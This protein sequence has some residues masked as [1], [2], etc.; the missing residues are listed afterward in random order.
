VRIYASG[1]S[2]LPLGLQSF[3]PNR[4]LTV[5]NSGSCTGMVTTTGPLIQQVP[6]CRSICTEPWTMNL[7]LMLT[8]TPDP[9]STFTG[10]SGGGCSGTGTCKVVM[11]TNTQVQANLRGIPE[12]PHR[13]QAQREGYLPDQYPGVTWR[14]GFRH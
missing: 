5:T 11:S 3:P 9:G 10:W 12:F 7:T 8:A 14:M 1:I 13:M 2:R 4:T 6:P